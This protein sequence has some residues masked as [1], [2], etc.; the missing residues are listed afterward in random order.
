MKTIKV[1]F[2]IASVMFI[3]PSTSHAAA[4][5]TEK[6]RHDRLVEGAKKEGSVVF[7]GSITASES[8]TIRKDI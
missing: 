4:A 6:E 1:C 2:L 3:L 7:Y 5:E 8:E